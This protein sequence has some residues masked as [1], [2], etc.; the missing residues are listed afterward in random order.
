[1]SRATGIAAGS[2]GRVAVLDIDRPVRR[3]AHPHAH[4]LFKVGGADSR[5]RVEN[6]LYPLSS[7]T[8][9]LV[10]SWEAHDY[11]HGPADPGS[12]VLALYI[13]PAWLNTLDPGFRASTR[14]GFFPRA[15]V[16]VPARLAALLHDVA[17]A[18]ADGGAHEN[19]LARLMGEIISSFSAWRELRP[20]DAAD[21]EVG[22]V[23]DFRIRRAI[24]FMREHA[25]ERYG[26]DAVAQAAALSRAHFFEL[27]RAG[28]GVSP[29]VFENALRME[30][31]YRA[32]LRG[33]ESL[34]RIARQLHFPAPGHFTRFFRDHLG[35]TPSEFRRALR[36]HGG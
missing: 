34:G 28:T 7:R 21:G 1:M 8:V 18:A 30:A 10:N 23:G 17:E 36:V 27:F 16:E 2:Y 33:N 9:I 19:L 14:R 31:S 29:L 3:H 20:A 11:P 35:I 4:L 6:R 24:A 12:R 25:G 26:M 22:E 13:E 32:L 5:F 15:C